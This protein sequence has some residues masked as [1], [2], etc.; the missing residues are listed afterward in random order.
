MRLY[1]I[2][3][4]FFIVGLSHSSPAKANVLDES[5]AQNAPAYESKVDEL[6][7][8]FFAAARL[9]DIEVLAAFLDGGFPIDHPNQKSYTALMVAA[10]AGQQEA[11]ELLLQKG[12]DA[13]IQDKR[14]NTAIM[15]AMIKAEFRIVRTLY[16]H[17]CDV[18]L[19]NK[20]GMTLEEFA[21]YWG[22]EHHL[23]RT[24]K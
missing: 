24:D 6:T 5:Q 17:E 21:L 7:S 16:A 1:F 3:I 12:A 8:Y 19:T 13:C 4:S 15:G 10:Y 22:Q 14:G 2:L 18:A 23:V 20:S 9:G 11:T